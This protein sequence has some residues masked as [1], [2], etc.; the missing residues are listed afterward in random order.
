MHVTHTSSADTIKRYVCS[1]I[2]WFL[3]ILVVLCLLMLLLLF[4]CLFVR[5]HARGTRRHPTHCACDRVFVIGFCA[6]VFA[7]LLY[8]PVLVVLWM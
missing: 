3:C 4:F 2:F 6:C 5:V 7:V 8:V 1:H